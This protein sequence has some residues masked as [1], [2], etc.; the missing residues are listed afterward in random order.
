MP[1]AM[2]FE[3]IGNGM[4]YANWPI[5]WIVVNAMYSMNHDIS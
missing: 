5:M 3:S 2:A 1:A 4:V